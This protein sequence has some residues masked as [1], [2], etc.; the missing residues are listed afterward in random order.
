MS[1]KN[2]LSKTNIRLIPRLDI[3]SGKLI[4]GIKLEGLRVVGDP[5]LSALKYYE[6]GADELFFHDAVASLY[7]QNHLGDLL[8]LITDKVFIPVTVGGGIRT[9]SDALYLFRRGADKVAINT[10]FVARPE[11][12]TELSS[13]FGS[14]SVV[15][16]VEAKCMKLGRWEVVTESGRENTGIELND[17][18]SILQEKGVGEIV[19]TSV[20]HEGTRKGFDL[21]LAKYLNPTD[22]PLIFCGGFREPKNTLEL[23]SSYSVEGICMSDY[24]HYGRGTISEIKKWSKINLL[25]MR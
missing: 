4:K 19:V 12:I 21:K 5:F 1:R 7:N 14:Q 23:I 22:V 10:A 3:K 6:D 17:W 15:G 11:F 2:Y 9:V 20:D 24:L 25:N 8:E 16:S 18:I 13:V